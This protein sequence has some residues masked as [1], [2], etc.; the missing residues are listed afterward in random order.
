MPITLTDDRAMAAAAMA[1]ESVRPINGYRTPAATG[2]HPV[3]PPSKKLPPALAG[4]HA[5]GS[6][7]LVVPG[8]R[9]DLRWVSGHGVSQRGKVAPQR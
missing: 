6:A 5:Q 3:C 8:G 2:T 4:G 1:G 9:G 7:P